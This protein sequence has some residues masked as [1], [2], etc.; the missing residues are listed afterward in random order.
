MERI[1]STNGSIRR[2]IDLQASDYKKVSVD[3]QSKTVVKTI[4]MHRSTRF[5]VVNSINKVHIL[6]CLNTQGSLLNKVIP[7]SLDE[8][9]RTLVD[10]K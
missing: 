6:Y 7:L 9:N 4:I 3:M 5:M 1:Y 8:S 2:K 10:V